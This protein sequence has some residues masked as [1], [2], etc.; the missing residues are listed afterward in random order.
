MHPS[1]TSRIRVVVVIDTLAHGGAER[2]AVDM[3]SALDPAAFDVHVVV[4][5]TGGPLRGVLDE[6]GVRC[7]VLGRRRRFDLKATLRLRRLVRNA[8][9]VHAHK[10]GSGA[11][12]CALAG[13]TPVFVHEHNWSGSFSVV[14]SMLYRHLVGRRAQRVFCVSR[15]VSDRLAALGVDEASIE[16]L[17]NAVAVVEPLQR[18]AARRALDVDLDAPTIGMVAGLRPEKAHDLAL[19]ALAQPELVA[20]GARL[21]AIGSGPEAERL[22]EL[23]RSFGVD[24]RVDWRDRVDDVELGGATR[25]AGTAYAAAFDVALVCSDWEGLPLFALEAMVAGTPLVATRVGELP[26]LCAEGR[27]WLVP[28]RDVAAITRALAEVLD[29]GDTVAARA[30]AAKQHVRSTHAFDVLV[31][32]LEAHLGQPPRS[33]SSKELAA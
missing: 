32:E 26:A 12:A 8:D 6:H 23:A 33:D 11:W 30:G 16:L 2:C 10:F 7:T 3:A 28:T 19:A 9:V 25:S 17:P 20:R 1:P 13:G 15:S 4:T 22:R 5:R 27:G 24:D 21:C 31:A 29:A 18:T 14:D